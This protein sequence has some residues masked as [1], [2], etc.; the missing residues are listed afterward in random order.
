M[1]LKEL[2][3]MFLSERLDVVIQDVCTE[4]TK[5]IMEQGERVIN[6]LP[7]QDKAAVQAYVNVFLDGESEKH[8]QAYLGGVG[9]AVWGMAKCIKFIVK[10]SEE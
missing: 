9:D 1:P 5:K 6:S 4:D 8:E 3:K 10:R 7:D 2:I